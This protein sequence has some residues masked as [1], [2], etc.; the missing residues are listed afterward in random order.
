M[1]SLIKR[2]P[3]ET[4]IYVELTNSL[5]MN[6]SV[7]PSML[8]ILHI[9]WI[10]YSKSCN[11]FIGPLEGCIDREDPCSRLVGSNS[12]EHNDH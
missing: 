12:F 4:G 5:I 3:I 2:R 9:H 11:E 1:T 6:Q 10:T 8:N 7:K